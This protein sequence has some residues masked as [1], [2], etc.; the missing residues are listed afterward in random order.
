MKKLLSE[1]KKKEDKTKSSANGTSEEKEVK[2]QLSPE[3]YNNLLAYLPSVA[4][5]LKKIRQKDIYYDNKDLYI[6]N[7]N[8]GL[9]IRFDEGVP[10]SLEFKSLFYNPYAEKNNPWFIEEIVFPFPVVTKDLKNLF[11][12]LTRLKLPLSTSARCFLLNGPTSKRSRG[13]FSSCVIEEI[14]L[15]HN[16]KPMIIVDKKR[17]IYQDN[18][19]TQYVLD[20]IEGLGYFLEIESEIDNPLGVLE[21]LPIDEEL[22][23]IRSGYNDMLADKLVD[24]VPNEVK[25]RMFKED[26]KWNVL[27]GEEELVEKLLSRSVKR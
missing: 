9:R 5:V 21:S 23:V 10:F 22:Q 16:L 17:M 15:E 8:R 19:N 11:T 3:Q 27:D 12:I 4:K 25:Q 26:Q 13:P 1:T 6:T 20:F 24:Y 7:L 18:R 2:V 14:L